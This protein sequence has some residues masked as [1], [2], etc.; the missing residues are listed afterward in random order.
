MY[1]YE[2]VPPDAP[3]LDLDNIVWTP[4]ISGGEPEYMIEE[5]RAV[6]TNIAN[7]YHGQAPVGG[8]AANG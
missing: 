7:V 6:L 4:H 1:R 5:S 3:L 8:V 2:P